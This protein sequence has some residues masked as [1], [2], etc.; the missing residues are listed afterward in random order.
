M[1]PLL[2][3]LTLGTKEVGEKFAIVFTMMALHHIPQ[4]AHVLSVLFS[5]LKDGGYLAVAELEKGAT[6][7]HGPGFGEHDGFTR[8]ELSAIAQNVGFEPVGFP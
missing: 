3:E 7:F 6:A 4:P 8:K 2:L 5:L 1:T